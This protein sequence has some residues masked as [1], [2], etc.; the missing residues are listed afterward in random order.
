M[1]T[2]PHRPLDPR[3]PQVG[4]AAGPNGGLGTVP[5]RREV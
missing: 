5:R 1:F 3:F 2:T 4:R